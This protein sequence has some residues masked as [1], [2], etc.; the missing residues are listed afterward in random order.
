MLERDRKREDLR[1]CRAA[2]LVGVTVREYREIEAGDRMPSFETYR[3][4]SELYGWPQTLAVQVDH[5][6]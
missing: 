1:V 2:W 6:V 3:R 5:H 4:I